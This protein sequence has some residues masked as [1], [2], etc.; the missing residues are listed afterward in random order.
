MLCS[1]HCA[2]HYICIVVVIV[3]MNAVGLRLLGC[4]W[5]DRS[6]LVCTLLPLKNGV[7]NFSVCLL[8]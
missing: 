2:M 4:S 8:I 1:V 5:G 6:P 7:N 3:E